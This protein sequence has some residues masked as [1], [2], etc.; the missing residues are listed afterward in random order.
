MAMTV[1]RKLHAMK[2]AR[3]RKIP[4][5]MRMSLV[6]L[7]SFVLNETELTASRCNLEYFLRLPIRISIEIRIIVKEEKYKDKLEPP[8]DLK[9]DSL[10]KKYCSVLFKDSILLYSVDLNSHTG[11]AEYQDGGQLSA[12][13]EG[14]LHDER[15]CDTAAA[16]HSNDC[17]SYDGHT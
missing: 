16:D 9:T 5:I 12:S 2:I 8:H 7:M 14:C 11:S 10:V 15:H 17:G 3:I 6:L 1:T 13:V 4:F